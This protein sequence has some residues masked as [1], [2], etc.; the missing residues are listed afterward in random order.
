MKRIYTYLLEQ[1]N[2]QHLLLC[3]CFLTITAAALFSLG[4]HGPLLGCIGA[5]LIFVTGVTMPPTAEKYGC[6]WVLAFCVGNIVASLFDHPISNMLVITMTAIGTGFVTANILT[7]AANATDRAGIA[8]GSLV[9]MGI[10]EISI[11]ILL[12]P[13]FPAIEWIAWIAIGPATAVTFHDATLNSETEHRFLR[14]MVRISGTL[15]IALLTYESLEQEQPWGLAFL[16]IPVFLSASWLYLRLPRKQSMKDRFLI[17]VAF[18]SVCTVSVWL[19][20]DTMRTGAYEAYAFL[21]AVNLLLL[22]YRE[23]RHDARGEIVGLIAG[24]LV[25][26]LAGL[27]I[28]SLWAMLSAGSYTFVLVNSIEQAWSFQKAGTDSGDVEM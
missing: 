17:A 5:V 14:A 22:L 9:A 10:F 2:T 8:L 20:A 7:G 25:A 24:I 27:I 11:V 4:A 15:I 3:F 26:G 18:A 1:Y 12:R 23:E 21:L 16:S 28:P 13:I 19:F 6:W